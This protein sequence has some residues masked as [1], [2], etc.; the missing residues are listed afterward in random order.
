ML[1]ALL[2]ELASLVIFAKTGIARLLW[3]WWRL[4]AEE[5]RSVG[6]LAGVDAGS[7]LALSDEV[8]GALVGNDLKVV[9]TTGV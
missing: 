6:G 1:R 2:A 5:W 9:G 7:S 4:E 3:D 8:G